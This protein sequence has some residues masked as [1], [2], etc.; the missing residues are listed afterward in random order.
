MFNRGNSSLSPRPQV[1]PR[2]WFLPLLN[3]MPQY[4]YWTHL[5]CHGQNDSFRSGAGIRF[6]CFPTGSS[7]QEERLG[8]WG[9][10]RSQWFVGNWVWETSRAGRQYEGYYISPSLSILQSTAEIL[11]FARDTPTSI[12]PTASSLLTPQTSQLEATKR[13]FYHIIELTDEISPCLFYIMC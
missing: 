12:S 5:G 2:L 11:P 8:S 4:R 13:F 6:P 1:Y 7:S 3:W 10:P 9:G